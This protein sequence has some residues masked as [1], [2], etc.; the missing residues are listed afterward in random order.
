MENSF[1]SFQTTS[2]SNEERD[3]LYENTLLNHLAQFG[4]GIALTI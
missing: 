2:F 3:A 4:R 1:L